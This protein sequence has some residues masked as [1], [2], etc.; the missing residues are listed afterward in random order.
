M[1]EFKKIKEILLN[2]GVI[3]F[4][5][6]TVV[7]LGVNGRDPAA[8]KKIFT[9]KKRPF[10]KPL[11]LL[12]FSLTEITKYASAIPSCAY[13]LFEEYFPGALTVVLHSNEELYTTPLRKAKSIGVRIPNFYN[14]LDFLAYIKIP[15]LTTSANITNHLPLLDKND[16]LNIFGE[17]VYPLLFQ[18]NAMNSNVPS[19]VVDCREGMPIILRKGALTLS[20]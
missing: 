11:S 16:V 20:I 14:L 19:T 12:T 6:D 5:T 10:N 3:A 8:V 18:H 13:E 15:L 7:G 2:H 9:L 1:D 4:P 17:S